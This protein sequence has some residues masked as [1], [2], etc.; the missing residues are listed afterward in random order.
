MYLIVPSIPLLKC[1]LLSL[2]P[3]FS[4]LY[5]ST[6]ILSILYDEW[7]SKAKTSPLSKMYSTVKICTSF[8]SLLKFGRNLVFIVIGKSN[9]PSVDFANLKTLELLSSTLPLVKKIFPD[10]PIA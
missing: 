7:L 6:S 10:D 2:L 3:T 5:S 1:D 9:I 8:E 4:L